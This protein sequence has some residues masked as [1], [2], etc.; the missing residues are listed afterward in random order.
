MF[1]QIFI[2]LLAITGF[3][4]THLSAEITQINQLEKILPSIEQETFVLFNIAEVLTDSE[5]SLGSS[6]W[7]AY[8]KTTSNS[9]TV[10]DYLSWRAFKDM[11]HKSV[12]KITPELIQ[13]LQQKEI[14]V[15]ALTS[16]GRQEWYS[17]GI[18]GVDTQT[19]KVLST[20]NIDF[21]QS[22]LPFV[23]IQVE[24]NPFMEHYHKGIFYCNHMEKGEFLKEM[25]L[26][27]GYRPSSVLLVDDKRDSL[28]SVEAA[29]HEIGIPFHGFWYTRT[30]EERKDFSPMV[31][32][33][34]LKTLIDENRVISDEVAQEMIDTQYPD[35]DPDVFFHEILSDLYFPN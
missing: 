9:D 3:S 20:M 1:N 32:N 5:L 34:Q 6:P 27:S 18:Y 31:A 8:V 15:A 23:Y 35:I 24:G 22:N 25:L 17:T 29:M 19:E 7:R 4:L 28:E 12:E 2:T 33:V 21:A 14:A 13:D 26:D 30:Q 11:P 16:R 10:H